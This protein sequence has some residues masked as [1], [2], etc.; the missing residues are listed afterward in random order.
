M[1]RSD[2]QNKALHRAFREIAHELYMAGYDMRE[3]KIR[4]DPT[5]EGVK[6]N[7]FKPIMSAMYPDIESTTELSTTQFSDCWEVFS[8]ALQEK[9]GIYVQLDGGEE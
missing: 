5:E 3:V 9:F 7:F 4:I 6:M 2:Q 8:N 1:V